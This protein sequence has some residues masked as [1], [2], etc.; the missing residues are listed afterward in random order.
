MDHRHLHECSGAFDRLLV[1][2]RQTTR[3]VEPSKGSLDN[4]TLALNHESFLAG[5]GLDDFQDPHPPDP[6]PRNNRSIR[7]VRPDELGEFNVP[8][9]LRE[10]RLGPFSVL[11]RRRRNHQSPDQPERIDDHV[12]LAAADFFSPR[13][14]LSARLARWSSRF[15]CPERRLSV[16]AFCLGLGERGFATDYGCGPRS[17]LFA[18]NGSSETRYD[19][20]EG[21][22]ANRARR[23]RSVSDKE[24]R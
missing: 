19:T 20:A 18:K 7:G 8:V 17:R 22:E 14:S 2:L 6:R 12:P 11:H 9:K 4:P 21:H 15:D 16:W 13:R 5:V 1:V 24:S 3:T 10:R 23:R